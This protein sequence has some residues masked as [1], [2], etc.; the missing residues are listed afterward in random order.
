MDIDN[1]KIDD[2]KNNPELIY[3][4]ITLSGG[5]LFNGYYYIKNNILNLYYGELLDN[6][7][8]ECKIYYQ[9]FFMEEKLNGIGIITM[10]YDNFKDFKIGYFKDNILNGYGLILKYHISSYIMLNTLSICYY[11][12]DIQYG[13]YI[14]F[15]P[16]ELIIYDG[17]LTFEKFNG[18]KYY[19]I[20]EY[21]SFVNNI[22]KNI[23]NIDINLNSISESNILLKTD[24]D[25]IIIEFINLFNNYL[26]KYKHIT[27]K[28]KCTEEELFI[29]NSNSLNIS[30]KLFNCNNLDNIENNNLRL[31]S[32]GIF[33]N[34]II[35]KLD[36]GGFGQVFLCTYPDKQLKCIKIIPIYSFSDN[37]IKNLMKFECNKIISDDFLPLCYDSF[38]KQQ[39]IVFIYTNYIPNSNKLS[40]LNTS[41]I[42]D[43][44]LIM[45]L[46]RI[47]INLKHIH[48]N[49][50]IHMDLKLENILYNIYNYKISI[51][52]LG[53]S[54][55]ISNNMEIKS[56]SIEY[57]APETCNIY[58]NNKKDVLNKQTDIYSLALVFYYLINNN[59]SIFKNINEK[60]RCL[61]S[62]ISKIK[63]NI[64]KNIIL[65]RFK[66]V[67]HGNILYNM[68]IDM[69][70]V[71]IN[72]R[73]SI[74]KI[75]DILSSMSP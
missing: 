51:I 6:N 43:D 42:F 58:Y 61:L 7:N 66:S 26:K 39:N 9:G 4:N 18:I 13:Y 44:L 38:V 1:I 34:S 12:N 3:D 60:Q 32:E 17:M 63:I 8:D 36:S 56:T 29:Y 20:D 49:N 19:C 23:N 53:S 5:R 31:E 73:P 74:E 11:K 68:I 50:I 71:D 65:N 14:S 30:S 16:E 47:S 70:N 28:L 54:I 27:Y 69:L 15:I 25:N 46:K 45:I 2:I 24:F 33:N 40:C 10:E 59:K 72:N 55:E 41:D 64:N 75:I 57:I 67:K 35:E 37:E 52:D 48:D 62:T 22:N 21:D